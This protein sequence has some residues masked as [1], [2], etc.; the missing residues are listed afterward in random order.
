MQD[1]TAD[2][3]LRAWLP[4]AH[5]AVLGGEYRGVKL[6]ILCQH[7]GGTRVPALYHTQLPSPG[8]CKLRAR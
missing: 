6:L 7:V 5:Q 2:S 4:L 1:Q 8:S 3:Y